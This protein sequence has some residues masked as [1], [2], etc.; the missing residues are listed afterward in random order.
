MK[1]HK[2]YNPF[3]MWMSYVMGTLVLIFGYMLTSSTWNVFSAPFQDPQFTGVLLLIA[4]G[5]FS[6][7]FLIGWGTH[8]L[9]RKLTK[10]KI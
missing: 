6:F 3:K 5:F 8:S 9:I 10:G 2:S 7:G 4:I 1:K